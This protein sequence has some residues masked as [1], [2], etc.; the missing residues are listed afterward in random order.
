MVYVF[1]PDPAALA[2]MIAL[3][4]LDSVEP[5]ET[6][7]DEAELVEAVEEELRVGI[8]GWEALEPG[9][10]SVALIGRPSSIIALHNALEALKATP[11]NMKRVREILA[12]ESEA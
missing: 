3:S 7:E 6:P 12:A 4:I 1:K 5:E 2:V 11:P 8:A 9:N 10:K